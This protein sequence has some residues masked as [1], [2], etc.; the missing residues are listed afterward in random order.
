ME[1]GIKCELGRLEIT[2]WLRTMAV[3]AE[4]PGSVPS[5]HMEAHDCI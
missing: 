1:L 3:L 2:Q 4:Y 5:T